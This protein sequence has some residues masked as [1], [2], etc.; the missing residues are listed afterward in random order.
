M[1]L[2]RTYAVLFLLALTCDGCG[3]EPVVDS[4]MIVRWQGNGHIIVNWCRQTN[5]PVSIE[6]KADGAVSGKIGDAILTNGRLRRNR[7]WLGRGLHLKTDYIIVGR[8]EGSIVS[9]ERITRSGVKIPLNYVGQTFIGGLHTSGCKF[10]GK[11]RMILSAG[12]NLE[13]VAPP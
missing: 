7:G 4:S 2:M 3:R 5:L 9:S 11:K 12:L 13:R 1:M 8:L 10:G 6:I